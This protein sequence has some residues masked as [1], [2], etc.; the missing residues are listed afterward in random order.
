MNKIRNTLIIAVIVAAVAAFAL[1]ACANQQQTVDKSE[2][3]SNS[4]QSLS[5]EQ[6]SDVMSKSVESESASA[7]SAAAV[8]EQAEESNESDSETI[9]D[10]EPAEYDTS[11][12]PQYYEDYSGYDGSNGGV[13]YNAAYG[14]NGPTR[15]MP[16]WYDGH[17]ETY[18][19]SN[20]LYHYRT[21]EWTPDSEGFYRDDNG[22]YVVGVGINDGYQLG[23]VIDTGKGKAIV[24]DFGTATN[25]VDFYTNW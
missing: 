9:S 8:D 14:D 5:A 11:Y 17:I 15:D 22:Y 4:V 10:V 19:S 25:D 24:S 18:Y 13:E 3:V 1:T 2:S 7:D 6:A 16:G 23:D 12:E 20:T 21:D